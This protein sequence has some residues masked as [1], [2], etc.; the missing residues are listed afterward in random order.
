MPLLSAGAIPKC[1]ADP[2]AQTIAT[3][4]AM[5]LMRQVAIA[6]YGQLR[7]DWPLLLVAARPIPKKLAVKHTRGRFGPQLRAKPVPSHRERSSS[8]A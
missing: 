4:E 1:C 7:P 2:A 6:R 5:R 8:H 3:G